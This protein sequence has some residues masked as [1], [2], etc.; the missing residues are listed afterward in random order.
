MWHAAP[1]LP[2]PRAYMHPSICRHEVSPRAPA[3]L[4]IGFEE[5]N[6]MYRPTTETSALPP[7]RDQLPTV[8][9]DL[10]EYARK[11]TGPKS[12]SAA[13]EEDLRELALAIDEFAGLFD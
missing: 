7:L 8:P 2:A 10:T 13:T 4:A 12:W 6:P 3:A 1:R 5:G 11:E 9:C